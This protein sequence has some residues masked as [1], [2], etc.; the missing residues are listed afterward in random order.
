MAAIPLSPRIALQRAIKN[1]VAGGDRASQVA[2]EAKIWGADG[3]RWHSPTDPIWR[4]HSDATMF[5]GGIAALLIQALHPLAMAGVAGHSGFK[6]DPWGRLQRTSDFIA[7]TTY[8]PIPYAEQ[9]I[10]G[11]RA[12]HDTVVGTAPDGRP[13]AASSP[14]LLAW[15]H[16]AEAWSFLTAYQT[17]S[18]HPLSQVEADTYVAQIGRVDAR[19]GFENPPTTAAEL[20]AALEAYRPDL[21]ATAA[22]HETVQFI[23]HDPPMGQPLKA[24]YGTLSAGAVAIIP[25]WARELLHLRVRP[26]AMATAR[27]TV[28]TMRWSIDHPAHAGRWALPQE[29]TS[30]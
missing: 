20:N 10:R 8:A 2:K 27:R 16:A 21:E 3:E 24:V 4:V 22:A 17:Y 5:V 30:A 1:R 9:L 23:L 15:V 6:G 11:V 12:V 25:S 7:I 29:R 28:A 19:L 26:L 18:P 13:Y 14:E